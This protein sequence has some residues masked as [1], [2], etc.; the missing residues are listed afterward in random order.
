[1]LFCSSD[2]LK[3]GSDES[4]DYSTG[5]SSK[6][7]IRKILQIGAP[8]AVQSAVFCLANV[9]IQAAI[10]SF[11]TDVVAGSA[12]SLNFEYFSFTWSPPMHK[13]VTTFE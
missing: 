3:K 10:N 5:I 8:A 7:I 1:V 9:V 11:G 2:G 12:A 4:A 13:P 6:K